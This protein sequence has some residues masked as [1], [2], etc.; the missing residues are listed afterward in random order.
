MF[1]IAFSG[2]LTPKI[3]LFLKHL[4]AQGNRLLIADSE[5]LPKTDIDTL[6]EQLP[7]AEIE[8]V[9]CL[10]DSCW[11]ADVIILSSELSN[12]YQALRNIQEVAT[13][14]LVIFLSE[15]SNSKQLKKLE[16][17]LPHSKL[18]MVKLNSEKKETTLLSFPAEVELR[19]LFEEINYTLVCENQ[20][21]VK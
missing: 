17:F 15:E 21:I 5:N 19:N 13:Q 9:S 10:K 7:S 11:E 2:V 16:Q 3:I 20:E 1:H 18:A 14:K 12:D 8:F 6:V 4:S